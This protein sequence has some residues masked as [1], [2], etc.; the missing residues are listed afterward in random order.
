MA[1]E[2][3]YPTRKPKILLINFEQS[4]EEVLKA[5]NYNVERGWAAKNAHNFPS[6]GYEYDIVIARFDKTG[7]EASRSLTQYGASDANEDYDQLRE[8]LKGAGFTLAFVDD[9]SLECYSLDQCGITDLDLI[10]LDERDTQYEVIAENIHRDGY[11]FTRS[12]LKRI[13]GDIVRPIPKGLHWKNNNPEPILTLSHNAAGQPTSCI[14]YI[15]KNEWNAAKGNW[16]ASFTLRY[17]VLPPITKG[18]VRVATDF[19]SQLPTWRPDLFPSDT[20][21]SWLSNKAYWSDEMTSAEAEINKEIERFE[22]KVESLQG[23]LSDKT[24]E[25]QYLK[26]LVIADDGDEFAEGDKLTDAS[27]TALEYLGFVVE[28]TEKET[29]AGK[30]RED[31]VCKEADESFVAVVECKGTVS[32]NPPESYISQLQNHMLVSKAERGIAII[33]HDRKRDA[34]NRTSLYDDAKHL[35][36]D[37]ESVTIISSIEL[38]KLVRQV[39]NKLIT[40]EDARALVKKVGRLEVD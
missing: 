6:P 30:R 13:A 31:L 3:L 32:Q 9:G 4:D 26:Q 27:K 38:F 35:W 1:T 21:Y 11:D 5:K 33:N 22:A 15:S 2:F 37:T 29:K 18:H 25:D 12:L 19:L 23:V 40:K 28:N 14:S 20:D 34:F 17:V 16:E 7:Y 39:Q 10:D 36:E 24:S 8:K